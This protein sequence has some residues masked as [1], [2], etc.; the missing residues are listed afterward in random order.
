MTA[1]EAARRVGDGELTSEALVGA[2][3]ERIDAREETVRAWAH[4]DRERALAQAR[5]RDAEQPRG[6][7]HGIAVGV[8]DIID[9][10][11]LP[12]ECGTPVHAGR[13]PERDAD[14]VAR[15]R[16]AGAV[17]LGKTVTTELA[18][19]HP[20]KTR[21]PA[22]PARTP[23]GSSSGSAAAVADGMVPAA[24]GT[25]TAGSV[26]RP[27]SF[28]GVLGFK[29]THGVLPLAG[30]KRLSERLDTL[31][32]FARDVEDLRLLG[33]AL[34]AEWAAPSV[35]E[36]APSFA[37]CRTPWWERADD[38]SQ[39]AV[40]QAAE[41]LR[42]AGAPVRS[43]SLPDTFA[44]LVEAQDTV[45]AHDCARNLAFE[46]EQHRDALSEVLR[47]YLERGRRVAPDE[48][49]AAEALGSECAAELGALLAADEVLL[50]PAVV[51][52]APPL[53]AGVTG[54]PLF[55]RP[56]TLLGTPALSVPGAPGS[57]GAPVGVQLVGA[58]GA[59]AAVLHAGA[60][61][62][63]VLASD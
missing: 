42:E 56:W 6:P 41:R 55:C 26:I 30:V 27:A 20:S 51:G 63:G 5:A 25:Q 9:T 39:G 17:V 15:L 1:A 37:L 47:E 58:V 54:D 49:S 48:A 29:P 31:G 43:V 45:Q 11:D 33:G 16:A 44:G 10:A 40:A 24:L 23:G 59:D 21:N 8:K 28:C 60:F 35:S 18:L 38:D 50:V 32:L 57:H 4:L 61:A 19:Y 62:A 14:C 13:R 34:G 53:S 46:Y 7:L 22:D 2:C 3:L 52:E 12:T 36:G